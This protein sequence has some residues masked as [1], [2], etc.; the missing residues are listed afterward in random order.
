[1]LLGSQTGAGG[2]SEGSPAAGE[3]VEQA[4]V[5]SGQSVTTGSGALE[6]FRQTSVSGFVSASFFHNFNES[7]PSANTFVRKNDEFSLNKVKLALEQPAAYD[8]REWDAGF[9]V[10]LIAGEDAKVIHAAGLGDSDTPFDLEQAYIN[11][12]APVGRGLKLAVGKMVTL[13]GVEVI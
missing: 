12:N 8:A 5:S 13:M 4:G 1:M 9:R 10:D 2:G 11:I 3:S 7:E 6:F